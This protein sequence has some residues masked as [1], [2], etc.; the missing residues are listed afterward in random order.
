MHQTLQQHLPQPL[1][2]QRNA[3][4]RKPPRRAPS[5]LSS[6]G[7]STADEDQTPLLLPAAVLLPSTTVVQ[8]CTAART[9]L[10]FLAICGKEGEMRQHLMRA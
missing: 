1:Q 9:G 6:S 8:H 7:E 2:Q 10:R 4:P 3:Q 5:S